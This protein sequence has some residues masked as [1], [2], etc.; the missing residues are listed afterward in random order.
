MGDRKFNHGGHQ[1]PN[2]K[3]CELV[4]DKDRAYISLE[5]YRTSQTCLT[6][7]P[8]RIHSYEMSV[9]TNAGISVIV[10]LLI[11]KN[12]LQCQGSRDRD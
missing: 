8:H 3:F 7:I 5:S 12:P 10:K 2:N 9:E 11:W 1:K 4:K 6:V